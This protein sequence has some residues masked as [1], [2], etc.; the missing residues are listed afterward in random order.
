MPNCRNVWNESLGANQAFALG[1]PGAEQ[2]FELFHEKYPND[3]MVYYEQGEAFECLGQLDLAE[4]DFVRAPELFPVPH[5]KD[6]AT[7]GIEKVRSKSAGQTSTDS[8][9]IASSQ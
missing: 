8:M 2:A 4:S 3:G 6:V 1:H 9:E 5:W 7:L